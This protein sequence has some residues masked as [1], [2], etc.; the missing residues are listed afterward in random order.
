MD[1]FL[2]LD[3][4]LRS[5]NCCVVILFRTLASWRKT[6]YLVPSRARWN[7]LRHPKNSFAKIQR[8][9]DHGNAMPKKESNNVKAKS[10]SKPEDV[11]PKKRGWDDIEK[12]F[13]DKKQQKKADEKEAQRKQHRKAAKKAKAASSGATNTAKTPTDWVDDGLGGV[14]NSEGFTG[15]VEDGVKIFKAHILRKE[16]SGNTDQCPFDCDCCYI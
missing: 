12:L 2:L 9:E 14:Y 8:A 4:L 10:G 16:N 11:S 15:R 13:D 6:M 5:T 7:L 1:C 3:C